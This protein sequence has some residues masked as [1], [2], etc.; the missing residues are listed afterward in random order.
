MKKLHSLVEVWLHYWLHK[1]LRSLP[2]AATIFYPSLKVVRNERHPSAAL[3]YSPLPS[4]VSDEVR[5]GLTVLTFHGVA[6]AP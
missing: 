5:K 6:E 3:A 4:G 2:S 1:W